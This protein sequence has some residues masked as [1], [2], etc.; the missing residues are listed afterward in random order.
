MIVRMFLVSAR[1]HSISRDIH[2]QTLCVHKRNV[3][4][5]LQHGTYHVVVRGGS[6]FCRSPKGG[7]SGV[8][9]MKTQ[10]RANIFLG[11]N[12]KIPQ[13]PPAPRKNVPSLS[14][15]LK[16]ITDRNSDWTLLN[17]TF[18][19]ETRRKCTGKYSTANVLCK[20]F[21]TRWCRGSCSISSEK[22][23]IIERFKELLEKRWRDPRY[24][25]CLMYKPEK[26]LPWFKRDWHDTWCVVCFICFS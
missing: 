19:R 18:L 13:P 25:P 7:G 8:F 11:K 12:I 5:F 23:R 9:F 14:D 24:D 10:G 15:L 21:T 22:G 20:Q 17:V 6:H 3:L 1:T 26:K 16:K 2:I 4:R